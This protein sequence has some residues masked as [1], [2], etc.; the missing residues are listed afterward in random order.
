MSQV[1]I[2]TS[3]GYALKRTTIALRANMDAALRPLG[4]SVPQ[5]ACLELI[6]DQP[7]RSNADLAR[8]AFVTRQAMHQL[9][10]GLL[11]TE[12]VESIGQG[13]AQRFTLTTQGHEVLKAASATIARI[14]EQMLSGLTGQ[15]G[16]QLRNDLDTCT[17]ALLTN[18]GKQRSAD[19]P[20]S[21][22]N[23]PAPLSS[24]A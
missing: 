13:R 22:R 12:L 1:D 20:S 24:S 11:E 23:P 7:G 8:G 2:S 10:D 4:L 3:V 5:Y 18:P 17:Q 19:R 15:Q 21:P 14:E 6:A 9:L 16:Q